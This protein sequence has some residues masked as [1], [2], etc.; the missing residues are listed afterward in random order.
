MSRPVTAGERL[1]GTDGIRGRVGTDPITPS[2]AYH[3]GRV[4]A[5]H[6]LRPD[7]LIYVGRDTRESS[8]T[9]ET[10]LALGIREGGAR[11][12][13]L[14]VLPTPGISYCTK[15]GP[16]DFGVAITASHNPHDYN[17]FKLFSSDGTKLDEQSEHQ[18]EQGLNHS[19]R[20]N[21]EESLEALAVSHTSRNPYVEI[22]KNKAA[23]IGPTELKAVVDCAHGA[24]DSGRCARL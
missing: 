16:A 12:E 19:D 13:S 23:Q 22:L 5:I 7:A 8:Q 14:G 15:Q 9:L 6:T 10:Y 1:F 4:L 21:P 24:R 18:I 17:G 11:I 20:R 3:L 2:F